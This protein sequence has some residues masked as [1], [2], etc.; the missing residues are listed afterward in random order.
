MNG[1]DLWSNFV[2]PV[3][4]AY[5]PVVLIFQFVLIEQLFLLAKDVI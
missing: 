3:E 4:V 5:I 2:L 1:P